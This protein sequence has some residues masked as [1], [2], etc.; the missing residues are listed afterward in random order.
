[1]AHPSLIALLLLVCVS[2]FARPAEDPA[3]APLRWLYHADAK[4]DFRA[5]VAQRR[6]TRFVGVTGVGLAI[7]GVDSATALRAARQKR[8]RVIEG[9]SDV[10]SSPEYQRLFRKAH[11]YA[12]RYNILLLEYLRDHPNA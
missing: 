11:D 7:P 4:A 1:M 3:V 6:D 2:A 9:T 5:H 10:I 12:K 8:V